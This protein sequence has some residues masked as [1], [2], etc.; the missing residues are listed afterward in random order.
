[1][2]KL[3]SLLFAVL[4][5]G[6]LSLT[7]SANINTTSL[8]RDNAVAEYTNATDKIA[9][10]EEMDLRCAE[11]LENGEIN[12]S[13]ESLDDLLMELTFADGTEKATI[14]EELESYGVYVYTP[15]DSVQSR[16]GSG[17]VTMRAPQI[18]YDSILRNWV[19]TCGGQWSNAQWY[20][21]MLTGNG[22]GPDA[23]GV[24]YTNTVGTYSS[25]VVKCSAAIYDMEGNRVTTQNRSDGDGSKGFGFRLQDY[26]IRDLFGISYDYMGWKWFGSCYYDQNFGSYSG[27]ATAYY[28][29]TWDNAVISGIQFGVTGKSA[30]IEATINMETKSFTAF[31][32]DKVFGTNYG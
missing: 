5:L 21:D 11:A 13:R 30:G 6:Q 15:E 10:S 31:S 32:T 20:D 23:F 3:Y 2:K 9:F 22:G 26:P 1:M 28:V 19:V 17:D 4:L 29:H 12:T 16:S 25:S 27:V 7:A 14:C 24:G 18:V 8:A